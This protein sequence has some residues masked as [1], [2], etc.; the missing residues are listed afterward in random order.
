MRGTL[1]EGG[2]LGGAN[3]KVHETL[4]GDCAADFDGS[5]EAGDK[6]CGE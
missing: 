6:V 1:E 3:W 5:A 2:G 4:S